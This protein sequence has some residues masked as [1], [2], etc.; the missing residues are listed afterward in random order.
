LFEL[1]VESVNVFTEPL[2][3]TEA[4]AG[5]LVRTLARPALLVPRKV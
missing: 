3:L 4:I 5:Q 1:V 2:P